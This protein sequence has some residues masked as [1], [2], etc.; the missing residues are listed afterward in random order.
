MDRWIGQV[1]GHIE[2]ARNSVSQ[3]RIKTRAHILPRVQGEALR[4]AMILMDELS[5]I[6]RQLDIRCDEQ[7]IRE[8]LGNG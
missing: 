6:E 4:N 3:A 1:E 7:Q 2:A 5:D 8:L